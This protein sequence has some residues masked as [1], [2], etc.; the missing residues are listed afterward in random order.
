[1]DSE[2]IHGTLRSGVTSVPEAVP[3][4]WR[5]GDSGRRPLKRGSWLPGWHPVQTGS[6]LHGREPNAVSDGDNEK[7]GKKKTS[8]E[9]GRPK[10]IHDVS[11]ALN[12]CSVHQPCEATT[13]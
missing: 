9:Q 10:I 11:L 6:S 8:P 7:N 3:S 4:A 2:V 5:S 12:E 13:G 1:M